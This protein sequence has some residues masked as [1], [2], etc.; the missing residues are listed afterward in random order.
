[1]AQVRIL[2]TTFFLFSC[3]RL[4]A[5]SPLEFPNTLIWFFVKM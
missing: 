4:S 1:L 3:F 2:P 5:K